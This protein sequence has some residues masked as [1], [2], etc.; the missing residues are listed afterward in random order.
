[1][2]S[3]I[4]RRLEPRYTVVVAVTFESEHNFYTGLTSDLSGGGLFI[5]TLQIRP[6]GECIQLRF[7][8]PSTK[9]PIDAITEVRWVRQQAM[10]DGGGEAGMGL[11]FLQLTPQAKEAIKDFL[12]KRESLFFDVD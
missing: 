11:R 9:E 1:M 5:A 6:V 7:T 12:K 10:P 4:D 8:L 3:P 2:S